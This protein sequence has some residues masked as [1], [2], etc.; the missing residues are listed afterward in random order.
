MS[1]RKRRLSYEGGP[2]AGFT[3]SDG[4]VTNTSAGARPKR[5]VVAP[6]IDICSYP[7]EVIDHAFHPKCCFAVYFYQRRQEQ[8]RLGGL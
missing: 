1:A 7:I 4:E 3:F 8:V 2:R 6:E 5:N